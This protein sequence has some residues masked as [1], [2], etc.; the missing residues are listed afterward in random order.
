MSV[1][2]GD[3]QSIGTEGW[4]ITATAGGVSIGNMQTIGTHGW[5]LDGG[6]GRYDVLWRVRPAGEPDV[7]QAL[8]AINTILAQI[9][10]R[11]EDLE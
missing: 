5:W 11:I 8:Q 3:M 6:A 7:R 1:I 2:I 9:Q 4:W 10:K